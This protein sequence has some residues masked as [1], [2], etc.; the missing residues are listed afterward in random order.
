MGVL[1]LPIHRRE[2]HERRRQDVRRQDVGKGRSAR[3]RGNQ[4][5]YA[6]LMKVAYVGRIACG[7]DGVGRR[8]ERHTVEEQ[9]GTAPDDQIL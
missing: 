6:R 8:P 7:Q 1:Q 5:R 2:V 9:T 3:L 4:P